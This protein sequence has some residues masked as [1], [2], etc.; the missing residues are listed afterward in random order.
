[1]TPDKVKAILPVSDEIEIKNRNVRC[2]T[3]FVSQRFLQEISPLETITW[4]KLKRILQK[5]G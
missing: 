5:V 4:L 1:M 2:V 3:A